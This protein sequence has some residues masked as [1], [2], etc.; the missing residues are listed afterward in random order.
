MHMYKNIPA[1]ACPLLPQGFAGT[2]TDKTDYKAIPVLCKV[3]RSTF[4]I[5]GNMSQQTVEQNGINQRKPAD[6][7]ASDCQKG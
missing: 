3:G 1:S 6:T 7:K 5:F 4:F 2:T